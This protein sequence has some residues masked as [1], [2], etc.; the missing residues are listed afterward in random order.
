MNRRQFL[1]RSA[2]VAAAT[3]L[4]ASLF[5]AARKEGRAPRILWR[6]SWQSVNIGDIGHTPGALNLI[7]K[8]FPEA[9]IILWPGTL[10][11]GSREFLL[12]AFPRVRIAAAEDGSAPVLG[13][14]GR[15]SSPQLAK[16]WEDADIMVH[17]SGSGFGARAISRRGIVP[18]A[19][20]TASSARALIPSPVLAKIAIPKVARSRASRSVFRNCRARTSTRRRVG[21]SITRRSCLRAKR[22]H[23]IISGCRACR[24]RSSNSARIRSSACTCATTPAVTRTV[25]PRAGGREV[26]L[27]DSAAALHALLSDSQR[28][29]RWR[30]IDAKDAINA[31]T[32]EQDHAKLREMIIAYVRETGH[33]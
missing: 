30:R 2:T 32:T 11:H 4:P 5:G 28:A 15:P 18:P 26:H 31:R 16:A 8:H 19:S 22:C 21:S 17:G 20:P 29:A 6:G 23:A 12:K 27:R 13:A 1:V 24:H 9:E 10:G 7:E 25:R 3:A 14:D 33:R